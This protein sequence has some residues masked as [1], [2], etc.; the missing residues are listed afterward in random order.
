MRVRRLPSLV[1]ASV[2]LGVLFVPVIA[3]SL[4]LVAGSADALGVRDQAAV[5]ARGETAVREKLLFELMTTR[6]VEDAFEV[7]FAA[8]PK[9]YQNVTRAQGKRD[10]QG[11]RLFSHFER[12]FKRFPG[13]PRW[14]SIDASSRYTRML[15]ESQ[16]LNE[17]FRDAVR[18]LER[19]QYGAR[20]VS[21]RW[22]DGGDPEFLGRVDAVLQRQDRVDKSLLLECLD[23]KLLE[24]LADRVAAIAREGKRREERLA[25][26]ECTRRRVAEA[27]RSVL[28]ECA[29]D[30]DPFVRRVAFRCSAA[31]EEI[32]AVDLLIERLA[33]ED[34]VPRRDLL[35][36]LRGLLG[37]DQGRLT[38]RWVD[39]WKK[40]R[41]QW[42]RPP[43]RA[44]SEP[45]GKDEG[46]W[47]YFG[48]QL[49]SKRVV[50][51]L[52]VSGS[53]AR[54]VDYAPDRGFLRELGRVKIDVAREEFARAIAGFENDTAFN[55]IAY[56][57]EVNYFSRRMV[58]ATLP[59]RKKVR[60]WVNRLEPD[61]GTN[62]TD[63]LLEAFRLT[64]GKTGAPNE[65][66]L[67][68]TILFL[69]DG[70]PTCGSVP[71]EED[72]LAEIERLNARKL[73]TIHCIHL[74]NEKGHR[75]M[76]QLAT[77]NGGQFIH[78]K[79]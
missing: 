6:E 30:G 62:A 49:D 18:W 51:V 68:D 58:A 76:E 74:G 53:M 19:C 44:E 42:K 78:V 41:G 25:A 60:E 27:W 1:V 15:S 5:L 48:L 59:Q 33:E 14:S 10:S 8:M 75:F 4:G 64:R 69:S 26:L 57:T 61:R 36:L 37:S 71:F 56:N 13:G 32:W 63:S 66:E 73:V 46:R 22:T 11:K 72:L 43:L 65:M 39:Y 70:E 2:R 35:H 3:F 45:S 50:F 52:D 9:L 67:A 23:G 21:S 34:G 28:T 16:E 38:E 40:E 12:N 7:L 24:H 77:R 17:V 79:S 54:R 20:V 31:T 47:K 55:V 29:A